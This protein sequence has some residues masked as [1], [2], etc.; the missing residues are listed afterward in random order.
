MSWETL[1][2]LGKVPFLMVTE[3]KE[4]GPKIEVRFQ[5]LLEAAVIAVVL[6][7]IGYI[8]IIPKLQEDLKEIKAAVKPVPA[9]VERVNQLEYYQ[10]ERIRRENGHK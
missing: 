2:I 4:G 1:A 8:A 10:R 3:N 6:A 5:R 9:L 7:G